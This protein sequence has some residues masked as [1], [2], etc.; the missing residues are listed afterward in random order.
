MGRRLQ[1]AIDAGK[2]KVDSLLRNLPTPTSSVQGMSS[3]TFMKMHDDWTLT[4]SIP[5]LGVQTCDTLDSLPGLPGHIGEHSGSRV[6]ASS[7]GSGQSSTMSWHSSLT[8]DNRI[9]ASSF[10]SGR[11]SNMSCDSLNTIEE[12]LCLADE[13]EGDGR[14]Q[15]FAVDIDENDSGL[16]S[17]SFALPSEGQQDPILARPLEEASETYE[18][19][20]AQFLCQRGGV[21][22]GAGGSFSHFLE[23]I[24]ESAPVLEYGCSSAFPGQ[25]KA[26]GGNTLRSKGTDD[27]SS[28]EQRHTGS[29]EE[30]IATHR[31]DGQW[32]A[33]SHPGGISPWLSRLNIQG[34]SVVDGRGS[35]CQLKHS[36]GRWLLAGG[37]MHL[38]GDTLF[39]I[40][41]SGLTLAFLRTSGTQV[42]SS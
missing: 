12:N 32:I 42:S 36:G 30:Q 24:P 13:I 26:V 11:S 5:G 6:A 10:D 28:Q 39:R 35:A 18:E 33:V 16:E 41:R 15:S 40:G 38:D 2:A 29:L 14:M 3:E 1:Q 8:A 21:E 20:R 37:T 25:G 17:L 7:F 19:V 34:V 22:V 27:P 31:F 9:A 4:R 23:A